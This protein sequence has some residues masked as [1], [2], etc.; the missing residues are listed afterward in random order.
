M[1]DDNEEHVAAPII[2]LFFALAQ[3]IASAD[4]R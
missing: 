1:T 4:L 3:I 2:A